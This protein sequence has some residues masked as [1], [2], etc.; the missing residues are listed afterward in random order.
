M[1]KFMSD[2]VIFE[3]SVF[4]NLSRSFMPENVPNMATKYN[5]FGLT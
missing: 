5:D 2:L 1:R 3:I 4:P